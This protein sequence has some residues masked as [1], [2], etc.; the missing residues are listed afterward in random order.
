MRRGAWCKQR[1]LIAQSLIRGKA[2]TMLWAK[3]KKKKK[4][5]GWCKIQQ[6]S[7]GTL[8]MQKEIDSHLGPSTKSSMTPYLTHI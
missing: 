7:F 3:I 6:G 8:M 1:V 5:I 4:S 2:T